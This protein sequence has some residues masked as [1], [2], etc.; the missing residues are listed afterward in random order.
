MGKAAVTG[1]T[2]RSDVLRLLLTPRWILLS[3]LLVGL[4]GLIA[5]SRRRPTG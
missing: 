4:I 5:V 1:Q 3:L 2:A